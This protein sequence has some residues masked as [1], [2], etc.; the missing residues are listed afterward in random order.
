V[1]DAYFTIDVKEGDIDDLEFRMSDATSIRGRVRV[2]DGSPLNAIST[3]IGRLP[4]RLDST[5]QLEPGGSA[6]IDV[7]DG[8]FSL[9]GIVG[10]YRV[11]M[12]LTDGAY[13]SEVRL[14]GKRHADPVITIP[15]R[16]RGDLEV[17][18]GTNANRGSIAG[19]LVDG[20]SRPITGTMSGL[21]LHAEAQNASGFYRQFTTRDNGT[22]SLE[23]LPP[24]NYRIYV[25]DGIDQ[26]SMFDPGLLDR[27]RA[28]ATL[29]RVSERSEVSASV[30]V[31]QRH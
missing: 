6:L 26:S 2:A 1:D 19:R 22:F 31:I 21:L 28:Q 15:N 5:N 23:S 20:Q 4:L 10:T 14:N 3:V 13:I 29:V 11:G 12:Q 25:W 17:L 18:I 7:N 27:S 24:G 8:S 30:R 9:K 16:F